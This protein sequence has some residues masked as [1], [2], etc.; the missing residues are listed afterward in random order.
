[1]EVV[2]LVLVLVLV[3]DLLLV[4][5][6]KELPPPVPT[7]VLHQLVLIRI[8]MVEAAPD[9]EVEVPNQAGVE[10][11]EKHGS[12]EKERLVLQVQFGVV[13]VVHGLPVGLAEVEVVVQVN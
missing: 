2:S 10:L 5:V 1:M 6:L 11:D 7:P 8:V 12:V 13:E 9:A 3:L 4:K